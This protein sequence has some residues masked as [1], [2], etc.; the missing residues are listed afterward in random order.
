MRKN[1]KNTIFIVF[2]VSFALGILALH[3]QAK[4]PISLGE[5][6]LETNKLNNSKEEI[7]TI[8]N[9]EYHKKLLQKK[10]DNWTVEKD[11][12]ITLR[13]T[14]LKEKEGIS[15]DTLLGKS[16]ENKLKSSGYDLQQLPDKLDYSTSPYLPPVG[17]QLQDD[18]VAW[19]TGY[20]LR[21]FQQA[22]DI[23]WSVKNQDIP[24]PYHVFSP[25]FIYNQINGGVNNGAN[26]E[27]AGDLLKNVGEATLKD[28]PY[29]PQ[30]FTTQPSAEVKAKAATNKIKDWTVLYTKND[31]SDYIVQ[32]TKEYLNT[33]DLIVVGLH[34][35]FKFRYPTIQPDG[36]SIISSEDYVSSGHAITIV[37]YDDTLDTPDGKGA[38]KIVNSWGKEWGDNGFSYVTY[39][40]IAK[41]LTAGFV[42][43]DL[44]NGHIVDDIQAINS[45]I[46]SPYKFKLTWDAPVNVSGYKIY[47]GNYNLMSNIYSNT[48]EESISVPGNIVRYIQPFNSI[49]T[50][51]LTSVQSNSLT[52]KNSDIPVNISNKQNFNVSF[53]G[54]GNYSVQITSL[55]GQLVNKIN[56][57][58][59]SPGISQVTWNCKDLSGN[60][61]NDGQYKL[62]I[63]TDENGTQK[64]L[65]S[66]IF[67]K[68]SKVS[69]ASSKIYKDNSEIKS[70]EV[71][72]TPSIDCNIG[73]SVVN[74]N[75]ST[76]VTNNK[77]IKANQPFSYIIDK[78]QFNFNSLDLSKVHIDVD[79]N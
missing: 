47:D 41:N 40:E 70:V 28:F 75:V 54:S 39:S 27:D 42:F 56:N 73:I 74:N 30:D 77:A 7:F 53:N 67:D 19:S 16:V 33:G 23:G 17:N 44:P 72:F 69:N 18:C 32:K 21:T 22:K 71:T 62:Y 65:Y 14:G 2:F 3:V 4:S 20:Y 35:G 31:S 60:E 45:E 5:K 63:T 68:H 8:K 64:E 37:G 10:N 55:D 38:F 1:K 6:I 78:D 15:K 58:I 76:N 50:G 51:S 66:S 79:V 25:S 34:I 36:T 24:I 13:K 48:Y 12:L 26:I 57:L 43:T 11:E 49:S 52:L 61:I 9:G 46:L 29:N 59:A